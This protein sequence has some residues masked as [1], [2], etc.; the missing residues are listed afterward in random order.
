MP[1]KAHNKSRY[2]RDWKFISNR[3]RFDRASGRC[4]CTG[5]CG[6]HKGRRCV[7]VHGSQAQYANGTIILTVAHLDHNPA[8]CSDNNLLAM[9]QRCHLRYDTELHKRNSAETKRNKLNNFELFD[10]K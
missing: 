6:L 10:I 8:N 3:I 4:E 2:P 7:E 5:Q 9:C 1:I